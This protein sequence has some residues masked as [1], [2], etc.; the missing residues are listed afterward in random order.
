MNKL[1]PVASI[2]VLV[3]RMKMCLAPIAFPD[4]VPSMFGWPFGLGER[5]GRRVGGAVGIKY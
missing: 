2:L 3:G 4:R 1:L 5:V